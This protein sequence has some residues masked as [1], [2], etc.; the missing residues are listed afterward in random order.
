MDAENIRAKSVDT[1][2][3]ELY[4]S[5]VAYNLTSQLRIEAAA[6]EKFRRVE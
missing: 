2:M 5:V 4:T 1:F 6:F 3:K